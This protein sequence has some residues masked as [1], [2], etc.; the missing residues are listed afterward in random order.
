MLEMLTQWYRR[1]F[2]DPEA[3][4]LLAILVAGFCILFFLHG[5]LAPLLVAIVLAYLLEWP[6]SRLQRIGCSRGLAATLVLVLFIGIVLVMAFVVVPV[7]WQQGIY[8][9]RDIPGMLNK[10]SDYAATLPKRFP[11][12][13]DAGIIDAIA[14]NM[15]TRII[16][17][18]DSVV[19][20][21]LASL[22]GL[23]TLAIYLILVPLMVFFLVKDKEQ[24]LNAVRRVL[25]RNRGLA[26]QV[27]VEMNQ[28]ITNYIR[29]KVLEMIVVGVATWIGFLIFGLN[30]SLL[31]AVLVG[32]SVLI[33]YIGA[34]MVTIPVVCVALFQFGMGTEFWSCFAVYL[35]IQGLDG[36]VLVPVLFSEAVN[37][38]PLV[39]ILSVVIFGGLWG[40]WGI[41]FAIPLATL[42]K[43]VVH[44]WPE[45]TPTAQ[46]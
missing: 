31:L 46:E 6:T 8:L 20:Y 33:P 28:Q 34:F 3:I 44:A 14:E 42:I 22:V 37:L 17:L 25:P 15:R 12:L 45:T 30:Y 40:F 19:K 2:S 24:L 36:N 21:S 4:A 29:G 27:W 7:A 5:L 18:G 11:A 1:R 23:L 9:I 10:L 43:A 32:I 35:I 13:M 26:G 38:H 39:I 16:T 41:F